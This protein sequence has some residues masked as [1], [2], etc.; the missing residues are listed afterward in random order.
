MFASGD[1]GITLA[2]ADT[3][4]DFTTADDVIAT[5]LPAGNVTIADG[6]GLADF[7][8]YLAAANAVLAAGSGTNDAYMAYNAAG[9][10]NGW[11]V[12]D[13]NDSGSV[14]VGDTL[15]VLT[16]VNL[17]SEFTTSDIG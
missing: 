3:I 5:S 7:D 1:T 14:D 10:G 6:A 2:A 12:V 11:L 8:A 17:A 9:S 16:G 13:E 15:I 4:V